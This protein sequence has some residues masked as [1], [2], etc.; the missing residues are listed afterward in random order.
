MYTKNELIY[1]FNSWMDNYLSNPEEFSREFQ[2][3]EDHL[4]ERSYG[5]KCTD[6]VELLLK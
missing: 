4:V 1:A 5:Q 6:Y 2:S 3:V